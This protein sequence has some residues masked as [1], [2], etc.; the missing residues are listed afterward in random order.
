MKQEGSRKLLERESKKVRKA[1]AEKWNFTAED[2]DSFLEVVPHPLVSLAKTEISET[3]YEQIIQLISLYTSTVFELPENGNDWLR[4]VMSFH[5]DSYDTIFC[6]DS[7]SWIIH[8]SADGLLSFGG[9]WLT[10]SIK[11]IFPANHIAGKNWK[12]RRIR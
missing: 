1:L 11:K 3:D 2:N 12:S 6:D 7:F 5:P 9:E 4:P 10:A 8:A